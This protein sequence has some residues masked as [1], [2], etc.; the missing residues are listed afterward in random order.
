MKKN[1]FVI[2]SIGFLIGGNILCYHLNGRVLKPMTNI[3][4]V[5]MV[6]VSILKRK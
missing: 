2:L 5:G 6:A 4:M 1:L 3:L